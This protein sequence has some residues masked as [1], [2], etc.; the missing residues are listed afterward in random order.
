LLGL[1]IFFL[2][3][4]ALRFRRSTRLLLH[5]FSRSGLA[6]PDTGERILSIS[7]KSIWLEGFRAGQALESR[8]PYL[9]GTPEAKAWLEGWAQG[10]H[11]NGQP[12][13]IF[14]EMDFDDSEVESSRTEDPP[15]SRWKRLLKT[16]IDR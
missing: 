13:L 5:A 15:P 9:E 8:L 12:P 2:D 16:L 1:A 14:E 3:G 6:A 4:L 11:V 7:K 10:I